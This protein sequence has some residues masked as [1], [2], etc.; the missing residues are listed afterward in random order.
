MFKSYFILNRLAIELNKKLKGF[1]IIR[2]FSFEKN[3]L[4]LVLKK[5]D[6]ELSLELSV[7]PQLPYV[8]LRNKVSIP[9]RNLIDFFSS[10][11]PAKI[12]KVEISDKD[13]IIK[14]MT[15]KASFYFTIRGKNTNVFIITADNE[16]ESFK[17]I[18]EKTESDFINEILKSNFISGF[19]NVDFKDTFID[20]VV[21]RKE[22]P[23]IGKEIINEVKL[24]EENISDKISTK[25]LKDIMENINRNKPVV[26]IEEDSNEI[27]LGVESLKIY[28]FTRKEVF[29]DISSAL[30]YFLIKK[31]SL[32]GVESKR[33][34]IEK[35]L[36]RELLKTSNKL[37]D[38]NVKIKRGS[39]EEEYNKFANILLINLNKIYKGSE[40]IELQ[41][42]YGNN[43]N[44][45]IKLDPKLSP[46]QNVDRYFEKA[47]NERQ[48]LLKSKQL[49]EKTKKKLD[50][51]IKVQN[52]L[53]KAET[54]EDYNSIM[55]ELKLKDEIKKK[56]DNDI[57]SKFRH[58]LVDKKYQVFVGKDSKT[59]DLLTLKFAKQND[60]W[61]HARSVSG[62][63]VVLRNEN[64]KESMPKNILK[65]AAS[66]AAF[67][68]K[69]KT[70]G[71]VPV[72]Y[73]QKKYVVKR[74]GME[75]GKVSL[76][77]EKVLIVEPGINKE[78]EYISEAGL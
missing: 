17:K 18:N 42:I 10:F 70:A 61:F 43:E 31:F 73:T 40:R 44:V 23:F 78:C 67:H 53:I 27:N 14:F 33:K 65:L 37:N 5:D 72:S 26:F 77:K 20:P 34:I 3:K 36:D 35:Y 25:T 71:M 52:K 50:S 60:Y 64:P 51:L 29:T 56:E 22:F 19:R 24:K 8:L 76:L 75:P 9:K 46:K 7:N 2:A 62:S 4:V 6:N 30:D 55:K 47:K 28:P 38:I 45:S 12:K 1:N 11:I 48:I 15:D 49:G 58:Y 16:I 66:I 59:N 74:K 41:N 63:H 68:S 57:K 32:E 54:T 69:A 13:R 21:L 39:R